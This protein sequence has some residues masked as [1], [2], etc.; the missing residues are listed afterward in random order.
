MPRNAQAPAPCAVRN[1]TAAVL[2]SHDR[3]P[4]KTSEVLRS[5]SALPHHDVRHWPRARGPSRRRRRAAGTS[6]HALAEA[7]ENGIPRMTRIGVDVGGTFTA[8]I[9]WDDHG[10]PVIHKTPST[11]A[12]PSVGT[13]EGIEALA[14]RAGIAVSDI[15]MFFHG[16]TVAT[17]IVL[18]H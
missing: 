13:M 4:T 6:P 12:D 17:N 5:G 8:L 1:V 3:S 11:P 9:L 7:G 2:A 14:E 16:T 18:E 10:R 15:E